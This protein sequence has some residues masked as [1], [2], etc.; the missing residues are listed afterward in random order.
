MGGISR[1]IYHRRINKFQGAFYVKHCRRNKFAAKL[2]R[3]KEGNK[4]R[5]ESKRL[6]SPHR[7]CACNFFLFRCAKEAAQ[8]LVIKG[9]RLPPLKEKR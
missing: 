5:A 2:S 8:R 6:L 4:I 1:V 7:L 3:R 9:R